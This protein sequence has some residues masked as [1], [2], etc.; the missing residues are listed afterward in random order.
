MFG[1]CNLQDGQQDNKKQLYKKFE[2]K[3]VNIEAR[4]TEK[5]L[6][7]LSTTVA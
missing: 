3:A 7:H 2:K 6:A 1:I 5:P 4:Y